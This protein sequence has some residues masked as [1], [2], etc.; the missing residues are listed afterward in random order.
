[1][2]KVIDV[3]I[4]V[5]M[6]EYMYDYGTDLSI[7]ALPSIVDGLKEVHR[8]ILFDMYKTNISSSNPYK[9]VMSVVG[10]TMGKYH[11]HGDSGITTALVNMAAPYKNICTPIDGHGNYGSF[12]DG[13]ASARYIECRLSKYAEEC[14][15][16]DLTEETVPYVPNFSDEYKEPTVLP[17][18]I[19]HLLIYPN[20]SIAVGY[21][22]RYLPHNPRDV[23]NLCI[24]Y[25]KK[26]TMSVDEMCEVLGAPDFPTGGEIH[27]IQS[28]HRA[29]KTGRGICYVRGTY[30]IE[31]MDG[32][33][34]VVITSLPYG[35]PKFRKKK[36]PKKGEYPFE[37]AV[38]KINELIENGELNVKYVGDESDKNN[39]V[40]IV[41]QLKKDE[42][43]GRVVN[44][45][46][47]RGVLEDK[48]G[49]N[50][51]CLGTDNKQVLASLCTIM[52]EFVAFRERTL[53]KKFMED[54]TNKNARINILEGLFKVS[55]DLDKVISMIRKSKD[56][57]S[58][59]RAK[60]MKAFD[61]NEAQAEYILAMQLRRLSGLEIATYEKEMKVLKDEVKVLVRM[62]KSESN[63]DVDKYMIDE[64]Q[65]LLTGIFK[66]KKYD[67][68][69]KVVENRKVID[70]DTTIKEEPCSII[71]SSLGYLKRVAP[72]D[73]NVKGRGTKGIDV[74]TGADDDAIAE[75]LHTKTTTDVFAVTSRGRIYKIKAYD[76]PQVGNKARGSLDRNL[77]KIAN[78]EKVVCMFTADD[79]DIYETLTLVTESGIVK[80]V[81]LDDVLDVNSRGKKVMEISS[82]DKVVST[83]PCK[84]SDNILIASRFGMALYTALSGIRTSNCGSGGVR[85][86]KLAE[87]D[88]VVSAVVCNA[89]DQII[90]ISTNGFG[91]RVKVSD[92]N[93]KGRIGYGVSIAP[94]DDSYGD[95]ADIAI[96][97]EVLTIL[98]KQG[99]CLSIKTDGIRL[100]S[101]SSK[102]VKSIN[103]SDDD[104]VETI[105]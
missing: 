23:V 91:K 1:M 30:T 53:H 42:D 65:N 72:L 105:V 60:L 50:Q 100:C 43:A 7:R 97:T 86:I 63:S 80:C 79:A 45:L 57:Y 69:T 104:I 10:D 34:A 68:K 37:G 81:A 59:L 26:R 82:H 73:D 9:K 18:V 66:D 3:D 19:P 17:T 103:L 2:G 93:T 48:L 4:D 31:N 25:V 76:I 87:K 58:E 55:N 29:Y 64:W 36:Q 71:R 47:S 96:A 16:K 77:F 98:S 99:K 13:A 101:R 20:I 89:D 15:L 83:I 95:V 27:G 46:I 51:F 44:L 62:T 28:V 56:T 38:A 54:L 41:I 94:K 8:R 78:H 39:P 21:A 24:A 32:Y 33:P 92:F 61:L 22:C 75:V 40:R 52:S 85:T 84:K 12:D 74:S 11:P 67:R 102:G 5:T 70:V 14:M 90:V 6:Q 49:I 35:M 88:K